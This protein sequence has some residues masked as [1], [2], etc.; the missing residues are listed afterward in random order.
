MIYLY[1]SWCLMPGDH[2]PLSNSFQSV[3]MS[4]CGSGGR[5]I[6]HNCRSRGSSRY[7]I[8]CRYFFVIILDYFFLLF[9]DGLAYLIIICT[10]KS[11]RATWICLVEGHFLVLYDLVSVKVKYSISPRKTSITKEDAIRGLQEFI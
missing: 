9:K 4:S 10:L 5:T 7:V 6:T 2:A 11:N 1:S 3:L 8:C